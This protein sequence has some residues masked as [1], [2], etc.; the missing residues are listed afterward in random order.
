MDIREVKNE[1]RSVDEIKND[2]KTLNIMSLV[3]LICLLVNDDASA[4]SVQEV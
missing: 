2:S 1:S 3:I 4:N